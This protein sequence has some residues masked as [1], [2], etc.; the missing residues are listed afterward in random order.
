MERRLGVFENRVV[1]KIVGPKRDEIEGDWRRLHNEGLCDF[2]PHRILFGDQIKNN[3]M[4]GHVARMGERCI[5]GLG[6]ET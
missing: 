5:Q 1:K 6:A 4:G 3:E 2:T